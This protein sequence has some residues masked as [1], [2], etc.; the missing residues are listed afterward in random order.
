MKISLCTIFIIS[1]P[2]DI[3]RSQKQGLFYVR[4]W[5]ELEDTR[6]SVFLPN[7]YI[8]CEQ[9]NTTGHLL[10]PSK[11]Q[12]PLSITSP[13]EATPKFSISYQITET[14]TGC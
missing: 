11:E 8:T 1:L 12:M 7:K 13:T 4:G 6:I 5:S 14:L 9:P 10:T 3:G 2:A